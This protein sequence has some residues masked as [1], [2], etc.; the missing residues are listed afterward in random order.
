[1]FGNLFVIVF[2]I[3]LFA[4]G[5]T[6][7]KNLWK[8]KVDHV[9]FSNLF[10]LF[11][12]HYKQKK[13][14]TFKNDVQF[15]ENFHSNFITVMESQKK[16]PNPL[17]MQI[18]RDFFAQNQWKSVRWIFFVANVTKVNAP[19]NEFVTDFVLY[20]IIRVFDE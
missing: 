1:M 14:S 15:S 13:T 5:N 20:L 8:T 3:I 2:I 6:I 10:C 11:S 7:E 17:M 4:G 18:E 19:T 16:T 9:K 12:K